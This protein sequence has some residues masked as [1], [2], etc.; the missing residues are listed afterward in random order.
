MS[1]KKEYSPALLRSI[2]EDMGSYR[3]YF[4][5]QCRRYVPKEDSDTPCPFCGSTQWCL[6]DP[7]KEAI[8]DRHALHRYLFG[9]FS[10]CI[11]PFRDFG[12]KPMKN[13]NMY[14]RSDKTVRHNSEDGRFW[15]GKTEMWAVSN[16]GFGGYTLSLC[17]RWTA[18]MVYED[19]S[20]KETVYLRIAHFSAP[21]LAPDY[22]G[23]KTDDFYFMA[24]FRQSLLSW[25]Y[26]QGVE[27]EALDDKG[28]KY[29]A[30]GLVDNCT[31]L[32][33][34]QEHGVVGGINS[35]HLLE[36]SLPRLMTALFDFSLIPLYWGYKKP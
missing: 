20:R 5:P 34:Q 7:V 1:E 16:H 28:R 21:E 31:E 12:K 27:F 14:Y 17:V 15:I 9:I 29:T 22:N 32:L 10:D 11:E 30:Y 33:M 4:C 36:G 13:G 19:G 25:G 6:E 2:L 24:L 35:R 23:D 18:V 8:I 3:I 26:V